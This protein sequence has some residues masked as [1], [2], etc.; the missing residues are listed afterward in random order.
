[1]HDMYSGF[2]TAF[3]A[4]HPEAPEA[5]A[6]E[7]VVDPL[8]QLA[9]TDADCVSFSHVL[10]HFPV[11]Y[12]AGLLSAVPPAAHI[13]IYGPNADKC[14]RDTALHL[15]PVHEHFWVGGLDWTRA[16]AE[17]TTGRKTAVAIAHD[18]DLLVWLPAEKPARKSRKKR[19][20][21]A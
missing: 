2:E 3:R 21:T 12:A 9:K 1:L 4:R 15:M 13:L 19:G 17:T 6:W 5:I 18:L 7:P 20:A 11:A 14:D 10:E 16:W 8:E